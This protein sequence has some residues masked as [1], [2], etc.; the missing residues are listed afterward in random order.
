[1][2]WVNNSKLKSNSG[3]TYE[4]YGDYDGENG[5]TEKV[6]TGDTIPIS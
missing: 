5:E 2:G 3:S 1:M 6:Q 4:D